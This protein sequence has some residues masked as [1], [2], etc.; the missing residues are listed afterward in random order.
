M[1]ACYAAGILVL[2]EQL[3]RKASEAKTN[4]RI[5]KLEERLQALEELVQRHVV[6]V[7]AVLES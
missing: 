1:E 5:T 3:R 6:R 4:E 2:E 7:I